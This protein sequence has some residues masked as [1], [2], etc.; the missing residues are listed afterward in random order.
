M[1]SVAGA[2]FAG[3]AA[4]ERAKPSPDEEA[5]RALDRQLDSNRYLVRERATQQLLARGPPALDPLLTA[6]NGDRPEPADRAVWVLKN[7]GRFGRSPASPSRHWIDWSKCK[8][9]RRRGRGKTS[10]EPAAR[11]ICQEQLAKIGWAAV[12]RRFCDARRSGRFS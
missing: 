11:E 8:A 4:A 7:L 1:A 5:D 2:A 9:A 12:D 3:P 10:S 6:A